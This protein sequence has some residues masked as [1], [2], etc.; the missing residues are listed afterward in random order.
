MEEQFCKHC[1]SRPD[2]VRGWAFR[3]EASYPRNPYPE[4]EYSLALRALS[5]RPVAGGP[6]RCRSAPLWMQTRGRRAARVVSDH[7]KRGAL[8]ICDVTMHQF[9]R[10]GCCEGKRTGQHFVKRDSE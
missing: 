7:E 10:I 1:A 6:D 9:H 8:P 4:S 5:A 2:G 3:T